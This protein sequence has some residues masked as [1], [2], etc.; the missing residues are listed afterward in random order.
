MYNAVGMHVF[1][2]GFTV[3]VQREFNVLCQLEKHGFGGDTCEAMCKVP[4]I[5][6]EWPDRMDAQF[7]YGNPRC[8]GF[9]C[10]TAGYDDSVHGPWSGP[11]KDIHEFCEYTVKQNFPIAV[12]ESVQ[13]AYTVGRPLLDYLRDEIFRPNHYRIAHVMLNAASFGNAQQRKRYFFVAYKDD[14]TFNITPPVLDEFYPVTYDAIWSLRDRPTNEIKFNKTMDYDFDSYIR[15]TPNEKAVLP[16]LPN[17][18][19]LNSFAR[20]S[21]DDLPPDLKL[22]WDLRS[23]NMPF[24]MHCIGRVNWLTPCPTIHSSGSR[25]IHPHHDR[26]LTIGELAT[27]MGWPQIPCGP[28]PVAQIAKGIVPNVGEWLAQQAKLYLDGYWGNEDWESSYNDKT[29]MWEGYVSNGAIEKTFNLTRYISKHFDRS[30]Y[31]DLTDAQFTR[32]NVVRGTDELHRPW[33]RVAESYRR[34]SGDTRMGGKIERCVP[35]DF[36]D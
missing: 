5:N 24:S 9:S 16:R 1:A 33:A 6:G 4:F 36:L 13:Q 20:Y 17:G 28:S 25:F 15:L 14:K 27:L 23:S 18:W 31:D 21:Y 26:P 35:A 22:T 19:G 10:I 30:R 11:T 34:H 3:G 8:T 7:A 2:G 29:S 12:W 32:F